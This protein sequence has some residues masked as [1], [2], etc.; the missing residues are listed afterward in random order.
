MVCVEQR[1]L[2]GR[3]AEPAATGTRDGGRAVRRDGGRGQRAPQTPGREDAGGRRRLLR[4]VAAGLAVAVFFAAALVGGYTLRHRDV[5]L[6]VHGVAARI[7][8]RPVPALGRSP[9]DVDDDVAQPLPLRTPTTPGAALASGTLDLGNPVVVDDGGGYYLYASQ[10]TPFVHVPVSYAPGGGSW[11]AV[12]DALPTLPPWVGTGVITAPEVHQFGS[13]WVLY[14]SA[15]FSGAPAG[16]RCIGSAVSGTPAGPFRASANPLV[17]QQTLGGSSDPR[18]A[19]AQ[20][21][22]AYLVWESSSGTGIG[23]GAPEVWSQSLNA[24][25][26]SLDGQPTAIYHPDLPWQQGSLSSPDLVVA[27][28][29]TWL[30]Y[31]AG[32]G[33]TSATDAVGVASCAGPAGPCRDPST[34][35]LLASNAQG[36]GPGDPSVL[37]VG[38]GHWLV[39]NPSYSP[40]G[41]ADRWVDV[42]RLGFGATGPYLAATG[43]TPAPP[44][45]ATP[46]TPAAPATS[47]PTPASDGAT[48]TPPTAAAPP[49]AP[50]SSTPST[51]STLALAP[52]AGGAGAV[53]V[54]AAVSQLG[55]PYV[56]GAESP[57]QGFDC[58]GLVQWAWAQAGVSIPRTAAAQY[59]ALPH[60]SLSALQPGDLLFYYNLDGDNTID[61]VVMFVGAGPYGDQTIVQAPETGQT[62]SYAPVWTAGLVGAA[63]P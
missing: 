27:N 8:A 13:Q 25:G 26:L 19:T 9:A 23:A 38:G 11:Q 17:C 34:Q 35:P 24:D 39:Y 22:T 28:G 33:F 42:A 20:D 21:G 50:A 51:S 4:T 46:A 48:A 36:S 47:A 60:V 16:T 10:S 15:P 62:V 53:A 18:V 49:A 5:G 59:A 54:E 1:Q 2:A 63:Q 3:P 43:L 56:Y 37:S 61:H 58:S 41:E 7:A 45:P 6:R 12:T 44:Q 29:R 30:F 52:T 14:F 32:G 57:G 55:V 31:S 40:G